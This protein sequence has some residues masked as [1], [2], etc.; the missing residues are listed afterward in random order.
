MEAVY[1]LIFWLGS[2]AVHTWFELRE[3]DSLNESQRK[4]EG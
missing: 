3:Q 4:T 1:F 2:A